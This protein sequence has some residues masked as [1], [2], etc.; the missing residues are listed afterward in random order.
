MLRLIIPKESSLLINQIWQPLPGTR[1]SEIYPYLRKPDLL[2]SNSCLIRTP[3]QLI[4][5][6]A[7]ALAAQTAD[8]GRILTECHRE[9]SRPVI[10]Y[11]THCH[12]DHSLQVSSYS[13]R[14]TTASVWI[15]IQEEG[16]NYLTEGDPRKTIAELYGMTFPSMQPDIRLL[17]AQDRKRGSL[18]RINLT[19]G[20]LLTLQTQAIPTNPGH[21]LFRQTISMGGGD[22]LEIYPAP[23]HSPDSVCIRIGEVLFI[24]DLLAAAN[25][26]VAGI[27]GWHRDD[28][29]DTLQQVL[30]LLD[31]MPI[32]FCYPGHGGIIPADKACD[33]LQRLQHKT[34]RLGDV[35][36]MNEE[37]LFQITDFALEL[38]DEAEEVFS[39]IAGRLLYV[40]YQ[41]EQLEEE[42]AAE[43]ARTAMNM[44]QIDACLLEFRNLCH[45]LDAGKIR[46]VEFAHGALYIVEKIKS[47]YDPRPLSAI[48]PQSLINRGTSLLLDFIGIANGYRNLEEFIPTDLNALIDD[49]VQAWQSNP[50]L[51]SSII[52]Y[53]DNYDTY[54]AA[55]V[56]R[57]GHEPVA[58]RPTLCFAPLDDIPYVRIAAARFFDTLLNFL[59]WLKQA[60]PSSINIATGIDRTSPFITVMPR[61]RDGSSPTLH[62]GKKINSFHR[63][64]RMCGLILKTQKDGF[65]LTL[66]ED[67]GEKE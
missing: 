15:A 18:R 27:S 2:S 59:E 10:I 23:G 1:R 65:L 35:I 29:I 17:T 44:E 54:L 39:S 55:L 42:D 40:A 16:A 14:M 51:D 45:S 38:I 57:L 47:L 60:D 46:R 52:D 66:V 64:F 58:N 53:A 7:G 21:M 37:R 50:H 5:I 3:E 32:R 63:R 22:D 19:P 30:W 62:E 61:G 12:I 9:R 48:L 4:L 25:P 67:R 33:I 20:V 31:N 49:V 36:Q 13:Q 56:L 11:L 28:L 34:C 43:R 8:L 41:L 26:M 6:D 24:G